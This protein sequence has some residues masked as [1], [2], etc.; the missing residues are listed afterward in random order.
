MKI[1]E[2]AELKV[3]AF[4][5][6]ILDGS[7]HIHVPAALPLGNKSQYSLNRRLCGTYSPSGH[8][9]NYILYKLISF[10]ASGNYHGPQFKNS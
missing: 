5:T 4:L 7:G 2:G 8:C 1:Y 10:P 3:C 9:Q 6:S